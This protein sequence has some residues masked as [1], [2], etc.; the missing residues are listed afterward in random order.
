MD[1]LQVLGNLLVNRLDHFSWICSE[2]HRLLS[3]LFLTSDRANF[4]GEGRKA[5]QSTH[6]GIQK[7]QKQKTA[8]KPSVGG[9]WNLL[10]LFL[11]VSIRCAFPEGACVLICTTAICS[12][13]ENNSVRV[14]VYV[15]MPCMYTTYKHI[16]THSYLCS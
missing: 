6:T 2:L 9:F 15:Y 10:I 14:V 13:C 5:K 11:L 3:L 12:T 1:F 16:H 8:T 4:K 7:M